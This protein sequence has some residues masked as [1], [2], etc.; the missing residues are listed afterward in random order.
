MGI[1]SQLN[2]QLPEE[3]KRDV[4]LLVTARRFNRATGSTAYTPQAIREM[5]IEEIDRMMAA[6]VLV[7]DGA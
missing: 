5:P 7:N 2:E 6:I 1:L 3:V 4:N